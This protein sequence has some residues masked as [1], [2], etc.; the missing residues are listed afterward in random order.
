MWD[1]LSDDIKKIIIK[2]NPS[3]KKIHEKSMHDCF[4][5]IN[6]RRRDF[7]CVTCTRMTLFTSSS[8]SRKPSIRLFAEQN[9]NHIGT[10]S[11]RIFGECN[12]H[13]TTSSLGEYKI[14]I[15]RE[16]DHDNHSIFSFINNYMDCDNIIMHYG[17]DE[18]DISIKLRVLHG[19]LILSNYDIIKRPKWIKIE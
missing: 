18:N 14:I 13:R 3:W 12:D 5:E 9:K 15:P 7:S 16:F 11:V 10:K 17:L 2:M 8:V 1:Y 6:M 19:N 4:H